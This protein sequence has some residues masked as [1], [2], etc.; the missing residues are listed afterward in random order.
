MISIN[1]LVWAI[2]FDR[3]TNIKIVQIPDAKF[4]I[5]YKYVIN[6]SFFKWSFSWYIM[7]I[8]IIMII[9]IKMILVIIFIIII[10][11]YNTQVTRAFGSC[12]LASLEVNSKYYSPSIADKTKSYVK[13]L[14]SDHFSVHWKK[15]W[16]L[17]SGI[18]V[19]YTKIISYL[20]QCW[21]KWWI[22]NSTLK[23][24]C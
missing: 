2:T 8:I 23:S 24:N 17:V 5:N 11:E 7:V 16:Y 19:E 9:M 4:D 1:Y 15:Y 13:S 14:I 22:F 21:W 3:N 10:L 20:C 6:I 18:W 12:W